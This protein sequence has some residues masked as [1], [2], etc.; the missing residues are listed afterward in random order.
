MKKKHSQ[1]SGKGI[2]G[3]H[4]WEWTGTGIPAHPC[5][6]ARDLD[7]YLI[8]NLMEHSQ[9]ILSPRV[10]RHE[11]SPISI[12]GCYVRPTWKSPD[13]KRKC[14]TTWPLVNN[15]NFTQFCWTSMQN[16]TTLSSLDLLVLPQKCVHMSC[17]DSCSSK[18]IIA[19]LSRHSSSNATLKYTRR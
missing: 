18:D 1:N 6:V 8:L 15:Y 9:Y 16:Y 3:F 10:Y 5:S 17:R 7:Q 19:G 2:R 12:L 4:S 13:Q 14:M 11:K